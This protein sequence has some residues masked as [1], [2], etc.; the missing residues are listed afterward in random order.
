ME[1]KVGATVNL[2]LVISVDWIKLHMSSDMG[3]AAMI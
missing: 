2:H 3:H 1:G